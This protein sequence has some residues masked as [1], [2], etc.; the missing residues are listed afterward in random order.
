MS[1]AT[2]FLATSGHLSGRGVTGLCPRCPKC[3]RLFFVHRSEDR[4]ET[5]A[6]GENQRSKSGG[7]RWGVGA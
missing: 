5:K 1:T 2:G 6:V 4:F 7:C 3:S